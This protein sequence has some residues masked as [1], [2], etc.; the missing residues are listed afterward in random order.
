MENQL[1]IFEQKPIRSAEH[2][3]EMYFSIVDIIE[4]LTD[5]A[6]PSN[7]WNMLKKRDEQ[8]STICVK[9][10]LTG[11]DGKNYP[12]DCANTEGVLRILMS[13]PSPKAE[14]FKLWLAQVG[15]QAMS[16]HPIIQNAQKRPRLNFGNRQTRHCGLGF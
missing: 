9:L 16:F 12:S 3:G 13:V 10:K 4:V 5:S 8:L 6:K 14:P 11:L 2:E 15:K 7:Y 1:A